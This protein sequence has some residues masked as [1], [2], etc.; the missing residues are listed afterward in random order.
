[1]IT[2]SQLTKDYGAV[3]AVDDLTFDVEPG[4]VTGFLGPNGAGKSTTM[5]DR[6]G[7]RPADLGNGAR[8]RPSI[9]GAGRAAGQV[10]ALLDAGAMHPGRTGR[11]HLRIA[12]RTNGLPLAKVDDVIDQV[13]L[14]A[15]AKRRI[16]GYSLGMRQRLGIA[17]PCSATRTCCSSTSRSTDSISTACGGS[18][19]SCAASPTTAARSWCRVTS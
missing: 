11:N 10:G 15:A 5:R 18:V 19:S 1:M 14:G 13:G 4:L 7:P 3:R 8:P 12:A 9:F 17:A 6:H 16:K 2:V